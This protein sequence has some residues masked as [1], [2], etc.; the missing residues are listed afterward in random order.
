[1]PASARPA[2][3]AALAAGLRYSG[4]PGLILSTDETGPDALIPHGYSLF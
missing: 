4:P 2:L 1:M 3:S